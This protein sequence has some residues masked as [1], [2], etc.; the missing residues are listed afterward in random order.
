MYHEPA[1]STY[2]THEGPSES[3]SVYAI[4]AD[5]CDLMKLPPPFA[6]AQMPEGK[7]LETLKQ[8]KKIRQLLDF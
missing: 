3:E 6:I 1:M 2:P 8:N 5:Y 7:L 4:M